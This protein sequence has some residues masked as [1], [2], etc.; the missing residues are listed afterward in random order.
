MYIHAWHRKKDKGK[1]RKGDIDRG[2]EEK[3]KTGYQR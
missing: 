3:R 1:L 2:K